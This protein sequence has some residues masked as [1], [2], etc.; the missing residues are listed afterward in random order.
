MLVLL[1]KYK[2]LALLIA[3]PLGLLTIVL[4]TFEDWG[5]HFYDHYYEHM[6]QPAI[7]FIV[8][9]FCYALARIRGNGYAKAGAIA[10][11]FIISL[12]KINSGSAAHVARQRWLGGY[13]ELMDSLQTKKAV[14]GRIWIPEGMVKGTFWSVSWETLLLS[15]MKGPE[16][17]KTLFLSWDIARTREPIGA[18]DEFVTDGWSF[19]QNTLPARYFRLDDK[20][21]V[22]LEQAVPDSV[23]EHL[24]WR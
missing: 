22:I 8:L 5:S 3:A 7:F 21:Y 14:A 4:I 6:L 23:L 13:L 15:S 20:P 16:G 9:L 11:I 19:K 10:L 17:S 2:L 18:T 1:R 24:R 12:A